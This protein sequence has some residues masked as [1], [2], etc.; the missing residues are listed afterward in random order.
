MNDDSHVAD[1]SNGAKRAELLRKAENVTRGVADIKT[2][3]VA[4]ER[5]HEDLILMTAQSRGLSLIG[6]D[7]SQIARHMIM[8]SI[9]A[10]IEAAR[11]GEI[12][13]GFVVVAAEVKTQAQSVQALAGSMRKTVDKGELLTAATFQDIQAGGKMMM[14]AISGLEAM[15][16]QL[17]SEL[18]ENTHP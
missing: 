4:F 9:N 15:V 13:R 10:A 17:H 3:A 2:L 14:A 5:W 11:A 6:E 7:L 8:V 12:A 1:A 16:Q 18:A